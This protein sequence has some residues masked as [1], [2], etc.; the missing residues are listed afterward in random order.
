MLE[1]ESEVTMADVSAAEEMTGTYGGDETA[2]AMKGAT[3]LA[4]PTG[5]VICSQSIGSHPNN[6]EFRAFLGPS[7]EIDRRTQDG[8]QRELNPGLARQARVPQR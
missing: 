6:D 8:D 5:V 3:L 2:V 7:R 1:S 4:F